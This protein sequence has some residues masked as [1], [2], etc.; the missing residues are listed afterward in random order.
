[1]GR[2]ATSGSLTSLETMAELRVQIACLVAEPFASMSGLMT[3]PASRS[4]GPLPPRPRYEYGE[5]GD[6][7]GDVLGESA[8]TCQHRPQ[9]L[10]CCS[11][12]QAMVTKKERTETA[13]HRSAQSLARSSPVLSWPSPEVGLGRCSAAQKPRLLASTLM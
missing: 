1:M 5:R 13:T 8:L 3:G 12:N 2:G 9:D 4:H 7:A 10:G 11:A 6:N